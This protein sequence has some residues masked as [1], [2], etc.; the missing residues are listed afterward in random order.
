MLLHGRRSLLVIS[1][2]IASLALLAPAGHSQ[3]TWPL[4]KVAPGVYAAVQPAAG[5]FQ[6]SNSLVIVTDRDVVVVDAQADPESVERLHRSIVELTELPVRWLINTHWHSDHTQGNS[7]WRRL[8]G[9]ELA[10]LGHD[11]LLEDVPGRAAASVEEQVD[12]LKTQIP[13]A[14]RALAE[15]K[16]LSGQDLDAEQQEQQRAAIGAARTTLEQLEKVEFLT[17]TLSYRK[18]LVLHRESGDIVLLHERAHTRGDTVVWLPR[19][20]VAA[21]GDLLDDLPYGGHGYPT[22]WLAALDHVE[23]LDFVAVV[24]GHGPVQRSRER[25]ELARELWS[26]LL[27]DLGSGQRDGRTLEESAA[28]LEL[29][30]LRARFTSNDPTAQRAWEEFIPAAVERVWAELEGDLADEGS[31]ER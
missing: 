23:G 14:D 12:R 29:E 16:G 11:S 24:P 15:G 27:E 4:E 10:I 1:W 30:E 6:D 9:P 5:R 19:Q 22:S 8:V 3:E 7:V 2:V 20:R 25:L 13:L 21:T 31:D 28:T 18:T 26:T 17:P